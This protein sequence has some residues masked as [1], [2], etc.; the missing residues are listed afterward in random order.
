MKKCWKIDNSMKVLTLET[1]VNFNRLKFVVKQY[2][3]DLTPPATIYLST[4][5]LW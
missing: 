2:C 5:C 1:S 4:E 3:L